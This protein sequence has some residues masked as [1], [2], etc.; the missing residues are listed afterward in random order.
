MYLLLGRW[1]MR[2]LN[3]NLLVFSHWVKGTHFWGAH[4]LFWHTYV[5]RLFPADFSICEKWCW[6]QWHL[7][8]WCFVQTNI[9]VGYVEVSPGHGKH[10]VLRFEPVKNYEKGKMRAMEMIFAPIFHVF[11]IFF[12]QTGCTR[13]CYSNKQY[14]NVSCLKQLFPFDYFTFWGNVCSGLY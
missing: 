9:Q 13:L 11:L 4:L 3:I 2:Y 8:A 5:D 12:Y 7:A 1:P 14:S 10:S 6:Q